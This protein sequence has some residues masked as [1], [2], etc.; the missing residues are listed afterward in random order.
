MIRMNWFLAL[1]RRSHQAA[2]SLSAAF[3]L[4][5]ALFPGVA[6]AAEH[7]FQGRAFPSCPSV[8]GKGDAASHY[9]VGR[10]AYDTRNL[11]RALEE[12]FEA[13]SLDCEQHDI[14]LI[15]SRSYELD[16]NYKDAIRALETHK[17]RAKQ[18]SGENDKLIAKLQEE[19]KKQEEQ[20]ALLAA[21][22]AKTQEP[23]KVTVVREHT[24]A[25][26]IL[27]G[28]GGAAAATGGV[29]LALYNSPD[30]IN[31]CKVPSF[32]SASDPGSGCRGTPEFEGKDESATKR[33]VGGWL[34][35]GGGAAI[36]GGLVW[37]VLEPTGPVKSAS[38][39]MTPM[40]APGYAGLS[41]SGAL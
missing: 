4:A 16:K 32:P 25:P 11:A 9:N 31:G 19:Q 12:F 30:G 22:R 35:I 37:Y 20:E 33:N 39:R 7:P 34:L 36:V 2:L 41:V 1:A 13:Y 27:V 28:V 40:I 24:L 5:L 10:E 8:K 18:T 26:W 29:L 38:N 14:L 21:A 15:I 6:H 23:P 17:Q 3:S